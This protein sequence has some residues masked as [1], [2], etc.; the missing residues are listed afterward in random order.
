MHSLKNSSWLTLLQL[1]L[2]VYS[3]VDKVLDHVSVQ[4]ELLA[5]SDGAR[6][7][8]RSDGS[9]PFSV[10]L[11]LNLQNGTNTFLFRGESVLLLVSAGNGFFLTVKSTQLKPFLGDSHKAAMLSSWLRQKMSHNLGVCFL[12]PGANNNWSCKCAADTSSMFYFFQQHWKK[13]HPVVYHCKEQGF[14]CV[15]SFNCTLPVQNNM[16]LLFPI[17]CALQTYIFPFKYSVVPFTN[18]DL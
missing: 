15:C 13:T 4:Y 12:Q 3:L 9:Q 2:Q 8:S 16:A 14:M 18:T 11:F 1:I 7:D 6:P 10:S 5:N 17:R